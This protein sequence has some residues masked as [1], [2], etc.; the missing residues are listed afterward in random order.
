M[1]WDWGAAKEFGMTRS[2]ILAGGLSHDNVAEAISSAQPLAVDVSSGVEQSPGRKDLEKVSAF[3]HAVAG[4]NVP[5]ERVGKFLFHRPPPESSHF[6][7]G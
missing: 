2:L 4:C 1:A 6:P 7:R 5:P 3:I